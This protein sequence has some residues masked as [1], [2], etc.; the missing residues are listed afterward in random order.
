[1]NNSNVKG[2]YLCVNGVEY[3]RFH[4]FFREYTYSR[5]CSSQM[6]CLW[7]TADLNY[8]HNAGSSA[9][10]ARLEWIMRGD[11]LSRWVHCCCLQ[12]PSGSATGYV[13]VCVNIYMYAS[14]GVPEV[15]AT[16]FRIRF[17]VYTYKYS[18]E[19]NKNKGKNGELRITMRTLRISVRC[20]A[21]SQGQ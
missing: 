8:A 12:W 1:M 11:K 14:Q 10:G 2:R 5:S 7:M 19:K 4:T 21:N 16:P 20:I 13:C 15:S 3:L 6:L 9:A 17:P 18:A